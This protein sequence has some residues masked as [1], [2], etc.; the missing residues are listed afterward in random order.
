MPPNVVWNVPDQL[1]W[2]PALRIRAWATTAAATPPTRPCMRRRREAP[3][4]NDLASWS[5]CW[6]S[7]LFL[8][9]K[10]VVLVK[11]AAAPRQAPAAP[12]GFAI[13]SHQRQGDQ[14]TALVI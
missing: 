11:D 5:N 12:A 14:I 2:A 3:W 8:R 7:I 13:H 10:H 6:A 9:V 1:H 4:A